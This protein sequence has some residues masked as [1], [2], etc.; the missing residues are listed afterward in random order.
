MKN[1]IKNIIFDIIEKKVKSFFTYHFRP[2]FAVD[3]GLVSDKLI[4]SP[5]MAIVIQGPLINKDDFTLETVKMYQKNFSDCLVI[6]STWEGENEDCLSAIAKLGVEIIL[7]Q[8]PQYAGQSNINF[9]IISSFAGVKKA[10]ELSC[11]YVLKTR[12]DQRIYSSGVKEFLLN[13]VQTFPVKPGF[14]QKQ[15]IVGISLNSYKYRLYDLSDMT[16]FGQIDDMLLYWGVNLDIIPSGPLMS[17]FD[18]ALARQMICETYLLTEFLHKTG[19]MLDWTIKGSWQAYADQLCIVDQQS[20]NLY[21]FKGDKHKEYRPLNYDATRSC[22]LM[23]FL[24][25]LNLYQGIQN[26]FYIPEDVLNNHFGSEIKT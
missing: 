16:I 20:L 18:N 6:I 12:S 3:F 21:W 7:N 10:H 9:Q 24:E 8:K 4:N 26:K 19:R 17:S 11:E 14:K 2:K 22:Q 5:K 23:S 1:K 15:R 25:W 13:I